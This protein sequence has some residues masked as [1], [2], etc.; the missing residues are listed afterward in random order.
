MAGG[1]RKDRRLAHGPGAVRADCVERGGL[2]SEVVRLSYL[3]YFETA[4]SFGRA[5]SIWAQA[6][7]PAVVLVSPL[8]A[9]DSCRRALQDMH[10][11]RG[12]ESDH[13]GQTHFGVFDLPISGLAAQ[14]VTD[15]PYVGDA[16]GRDGMTLGFQAA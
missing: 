13:V 14:V 9:S 16:G 3:V 6:T 12:T 11:A 8:W 7:I 2:R 10:A 4:F 5:W 1:R 15:L